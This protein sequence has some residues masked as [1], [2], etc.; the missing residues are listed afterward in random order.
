MTIQQKYRY[1]KFTFKF[2]IILKIMANRS[3]WSIDEALTCITTLDQRGPAT[4]NHEG[5]I[6]L[7]TGL[8]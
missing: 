7:F 2:K 5:V 3:V 1:F 6:P 4:N 8:K